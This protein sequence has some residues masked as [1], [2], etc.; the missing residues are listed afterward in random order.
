MLMKRLIVFLAILICVGACDKDIP[1]KYE[2]LCIL[3]Y[4]A[5]TEK[6]ISGVFLTLVRLSDDR[7][8][9]GVTD[10]NGKFCFPDLKSGDY[11]IRLEKENYEIRTGTISVIINKENNYPYPLKGVPASLNLEPTVLTTELDFGENLNTEQFRFRNDH[12]IEIS[13]RIF[14]SCSWIKSVLSHSNERDFGTLAAGRTETVT[15]IIDREKLLQAGTNEDNISVGTSEHGGAKVKIVAFNKHEKPIVVTNEVT[16]ITTTNAT[17]NGTIT[18]EGRPAYTERGFVYSK[19]PNPT[20]ENRLGQQTIPATSTATFFTVIPITANETYYVKAYAINSSG[21]AYG[22]EITFTG[23]VELAT[24]STNAATSIT[25][26]SAVLGG[27]IITTGAPTYTEKGIC[28]ST[29][30]LPT[31]ENGSKIII[32]GSITGD[33]AQNVTGLISGTRYYVRAYARTDNSGVAYGN[34]LQFTTLAPVTVSTQS[35][36]SSNVTTSTATVYGSILNTGVPAYSEKGICYA[37]SNNPTIE[38]AFSTPVSGT[39]VGAYSANLSSLEA[40][41]LYY[42]RAYAKNELGVVY[43]NTINFT[44][45][46]EKATVSTQAPTQLSGSSVRLNGTIGNVGN[47]N[48]IE[49]GF[50]CSMSSSPT[51]TDTK[52]IVSGQGASTFSATFNYGNNYI[53]SY[54][55]RA[56]VINADRSVDYGQDHLFFFDVVF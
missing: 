53:Y 14:H 1:D 49:K 32:L 28:Y 45:K 22:N 3:V 2:D 5:D 27:I 51:I 18:Y 36:L 52:I 44:T 42:A 13:W 29:S 19:S 34:E 16:S 48:Y 30:S 47:P 38:T 4:D 9:L 35:V 15:V 40:Y 50:V 21:T 8:F 7:D 33:F 11:S 31:I 41:T 6:P 37:L 26:T 20:I 25:T 12:D 54:H 23:G 55:V 56:Y 43:G 10:L 17:L 39:G 24:L 46:I